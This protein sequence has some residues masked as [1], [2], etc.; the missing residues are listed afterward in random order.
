MKIG[1]FAS[2]TKQSNYNFHFEPPRG[3]PPKRRHPSRDIVEFC[4]EVWW[5]DGRRGASRNEF[6]IGVN[7]VWN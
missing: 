3:P 7:Y 5:R 2:S 6:S 1:R 4:G